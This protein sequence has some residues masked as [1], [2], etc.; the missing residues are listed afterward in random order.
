L[1]YPTA[2][3]QIPSDQI[4]PGSGVYA[5]FAELGAERF[6]AA[7]SVGTNPHFNGTTTTVEAYLL[8]FDRDIYGETLRLLFVERLREQA[9]FET[10]DDLL[11]QMA[12][13]VQNARRITEAEESDDSG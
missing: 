7:V 12:R 5:A 2:N 13:D 6:A 3:L 9:R 4:V 11:A 10:L 8:D 1:G